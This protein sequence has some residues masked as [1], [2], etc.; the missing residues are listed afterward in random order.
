[1]TFQTT[2]RVNQADGL[3]GELYNNSPIRSN[4]LILD[5]SSNPSAVNTVGY[6]FTRIDGEDDKAAIGNLGAG[7]FAGILF[8]PKTLESNGTA[9]AALDPTLEVPNFDQ[10]E[11]LTMGE[12]RVILESVGTGKIGEEIRYDSTTGALS[13]NDTP[14]SGYTQLVGAKISRFNV[15]GTDVLAVIKL[16]EPTTVITP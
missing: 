4:Q 6:A 13:A 11:F 1:M 12:I 16:T 7:E 2:V 9:T 5:S 15:T 8:N 14:A 10:A 3:P